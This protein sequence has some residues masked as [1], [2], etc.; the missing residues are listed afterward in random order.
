MKVLK[1]SEQM[2]EQTKEE[3]YDFIEK[4]RDQANQFYYKIEDNPN[5][6]EIEVQQKFEIIYDRL[7]SILSEM[8]RLVDY[9]S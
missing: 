4:A 1:G 3:M 2:T 9:S 5:L 7:H 8:E 6:S